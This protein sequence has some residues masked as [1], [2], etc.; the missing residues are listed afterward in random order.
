M[1][2]VTITTKVFQTSATTT[3]TVSGSGTYDNT[4]GEFIV[5]Y[6][7]VKKV[8]AFTIAGGVVITTTTEDANTHTFTKI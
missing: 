4:T 3:R 2:N 5:D 1:G 8:Y 7:V 6:T